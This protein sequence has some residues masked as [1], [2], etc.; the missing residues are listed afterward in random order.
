VLLDDLEY[1]YKH[2]K[3]DTLKAFFRTLIDVRDIHI[4]G[5]I[6]L[7]GWGLWQFDQRL[8]FTV[9]GVIL[10]YLGAFSGKKRS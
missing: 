1:S 6:A 9:V 7:I 2:S 8:S 10:L 3:G 5:G 4:Y